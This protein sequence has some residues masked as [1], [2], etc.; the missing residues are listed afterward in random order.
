MQ[1]IRSAAL[2]LMAAVV[3]A[4]FLLDSV[5]H[6]ATSPHD[7]DQILRMINEVTPRVELF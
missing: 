5:T 3:M 1:V 7:P 6:G 2:A 4:A